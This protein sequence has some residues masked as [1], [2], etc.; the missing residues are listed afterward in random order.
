MERLCAANIDLT[1]TISQLIDSSTSDENAN[2]SYVLNCLLT[3]ARQQTAA[4]GKTG[5]CHQ[6]AIKD[7]A[8]YIFM[9]GGRLCYETL[10]MN[11]PLPSPTTIGR[12][13]HDNGPEVIEGVMRCSQL[14][15]FLEDRQLPMTVWVS[16]DGTRFTSRLQYDPGTNQIVG[17][18]LPI[19]KNGMPVAKSFLATSAKAM[20]E[21]SDVHSEFSLNIILAFFEF[22]KFLHNNGPA[23]L[24][25]RTAILS[26]TI[27]KINL[28]PRML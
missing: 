9:L 10:Y 27:W 18:L 22:F 4:K 12:Y 21:Q 25:A 15:K 23:S 16:E 6:S 24:L 28:F 7:F 20:N 3:A 26:S 17:L 5:H 14:K 11:L 1:Q 8:C 19:D 13:L 2:Y